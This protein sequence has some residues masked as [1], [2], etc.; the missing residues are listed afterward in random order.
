MLGID[1]TKPQTFLVLGIWAGLESPACLE[2]SKQRIKC[3]VESADHEQKL[4]LQTQDLLWKNVRV[5]NRYVAFCYRN[6]VLNLFGFTWRDD[7][8]LS[9]EVFP[10]LRNLGFIHR[11][12]VL[13]RNRVF[14]LLTPVRNLCALTHP[15]EYLLHFLLEALERTS[16]KE[17]RAALEGR[18]WAWFVVF[19]RI[20]LSHFYQQGFP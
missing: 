19:Q 16:P 9:F 10:Y 12:L 20:H 2:L 17:V 6:A 18:W 3:M 5:T 13:H 1:L 8:F 7:L 14:S 11:E 15:A 4:N